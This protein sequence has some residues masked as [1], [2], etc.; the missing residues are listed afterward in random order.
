MFVSG[1]AGPDVKLPVAHN[2]AVPP[3]GSVSCV[4]A[5]VMDWSTGARQVTVVEPVVVP[6]A[7]APL[8]EIVA[9]PPAV[10][11]ALQLTRP[12]ATV[13]T[14]GALVTQVAAASRFSWSR[15]CKYR[16]PSTAPCRP[17]PLAAPVASH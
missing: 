3:V 4:G 6:V 11:L 15:R 16:W 5:I 9:E 2:C 17:P 7:V 10:A 12:V 1:C 13:A 8:A 14:L